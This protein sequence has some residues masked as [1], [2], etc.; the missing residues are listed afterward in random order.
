MVCITFDICVGCICGKPGV[1]MNNK[2]FE[3]TCQ[4]YY[5]DMTFQEAFEKTRKHVCISV[6]ASTL[7]T[8]VSVRPLL[9]RS[10][11]FVIIVCID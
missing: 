6:S 3:R 8:K 1:L 5:G 7:G 11:V 9:L 2:D 4:F 10:H